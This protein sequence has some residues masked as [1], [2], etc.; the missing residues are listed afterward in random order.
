MT[1]RST[2]AAVSD[3]SSSGP[4]RVRLDPAASAMVWMGPG[5]PHEATAFLSVELQPGEALVEVELATVC[6]SDVHTTAGDRSAPTPLVLG[7]EQLGR[8]AALA[9]DVVTADGTPLAVGDRVLWS[10]AASC[11]S[12][13]RCARGLPQKC[14]SL[15]KY[16]HERLTEEWSLSG[17]F[18]THVHVRRGTPIVRV[19]DAVP[20]AALA[21]VSCGTATA[22]A[23][24]DAASRVVPLDGARVLI[25]GAGL[26]GLTASAI[27][28]DRGAHVV[29]A[30]PDRARRALARSFGAVST[31]DPTA[32]NAERHRT[33]AGG[34][35]GFDV[36]LEASGA[37]AAVT[38]A[39]ESAAVGGA[40]VLVGSV[41]PTE[42][43]GVDPE[44][45]VRRLLTIRGVHNY[46]GRHLREAAEYMERRVD[47]YPFASLVGTILP[48]DRLDE[49][50]VT[51]HGDRH[52]RV[53]VTPRP[54]G[55][56]DPALT[57]SH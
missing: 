19:S 32:R 45:L 16:G 34:E 44:S 9:G 6:G 49:A 18:A 21:P 37:R 36:V 28:T 47:A 40:V 5:R 54:A 27:A 1:L 31:L 26:I 42:P 25:T 8:V 56:T 41:F 10:I 39:I 46:T 17:G 7:H 22:W 24:L 14:R 57:R 2:D 15:R 20:A 38:T 3:A 30:D 43:I 52:V 33:E 50:I 4:V 29:V 48:L 23:A 11:D 12:C 35:D 13:D 51:A 55:R 53:G